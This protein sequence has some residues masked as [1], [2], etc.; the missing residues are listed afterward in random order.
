MK[1]L[2]IATAVSAA[3]VVG[4]GSALAFQCPGL[5]KQGRDAAAKMDA[6]DAKVA[7]AVSML[8]QAESLHKAGKH[9]ESVKEANEA[10]GLLGV[11]K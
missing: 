7:K 2:M 3:L 4:A 10:L 8:D 6:K 9:A 11:K 1:T 5:I